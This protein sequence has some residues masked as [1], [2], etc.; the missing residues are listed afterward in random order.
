LALLLVSC[1]RKQVAPADKFREIRSAVLRGQLVRARSEAD[2][3]YHRFQG[4]DQEWAWK[5]RLLEGDALAS[6]G[7]SQDILSLLAAELPQSLANSDLAARKHMLQALAYSHLGDF[8]SADRHLREA[9]RICDALNCESAGEVAR[10]AGVVA[11]D[12]DDPDTAES[13]F[14]KSLEIARQQGDQF[15]EVSS[16]LNLGV[17][18][19]GRERFDESVQWSS[20]AQRVARIIPSGL[21]EEKA[22]GN[23]GWAYYKMGDFDRSLVQ[24]ADASRKAGELGVVIDQVEWLNNLGLVYFQTGQLSLAENY[25][26]QSLALAQKSGNR[27]Q[28]IAALTA[29]AYLSVQTKQLDEAK[30][31]SQQAFQ[32]AHSIGDR[33]GELAPM[34]VQGQIAARV[35]DPQNAERIFR[36]VS[37]D[38]KSDASLRWEAQDDLAKLYEDEHLAAQADLRYRKALASFESARSALQH[39]ESRLP[40]LGNATELYDD[41]LHFLI[42]QGRIVDALQL[43][44][45][46][47]AQ[48]LAEGLGLPNSD[49]ANIRA[50]P[51]PKRIAAKTNSTILYYWLGTKTSYR[52]TVSSSQITLA[53]LPP[54]AEINELAEKYRRELLGPRDVVETQNSDGSRLFDLLVGHAAP[55]PGSGSRVVIIPD[56]SLNNLNFETLLVSAPRS[57]YWI[58]DVTIVNANSLR[59][60]AAGHRTSPTNAR[61]LLLMGD[62][63]TPSREYQDLPEAGLEVTNIERHFTSTNRRVYTRADAT[64]P[65]YLASAPERFEFIHFVAHGTSTRLN[66]LDSAV[67]LSKAS[68]EEDSFKLYA[69]DIVQH[70]L[71][72]QLVTISTC[73]GAGT[74]SYAGEGLVGLSWAFLRAGAHNVIGALWEVSDTSTPHLMD[75]L[76]SEL[77]AGRSPEVALRS[78]KLALLHSNSVFRKPFYWAP[79][80]LYS[81]S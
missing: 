56:G 3:Q 60:L 49:P 36:E 65:A 62:A 78:A 47:R 16:L 22:S 74:R 61:K 57:H 52:W 20:D 17:V 27:G 13:C 53:K 26:R 34:V 11:V 71:H 81:G 73:Y 45:Y 46:G 63:V 8:P 70:P 24:Y 50:N 76:Y 59:L 41:Y 4:H 77:Q 2:Q 6:Q 54:A 66:P 58:E 33:A 25:Y 29:L 37:N 19:I 38:S 80:Q 39:E 79:F 14:R 48:T 18:A 40:F 9:Q 12:R 67:I 72:A 55:T 51:D 28:V 44:D 5:F 75:E 7:L 69:R 43:A 15:L 31:Y 23:L 42:A 30:Q 21:D 68:S 35:G 10:I 64:P 1:N 32:L